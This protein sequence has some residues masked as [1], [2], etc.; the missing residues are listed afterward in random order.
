[1]F[2]TIGVNIIYNNKFNVLFRYGKQD[3]VLMGVGITTYC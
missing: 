1:M 2:A 3:E